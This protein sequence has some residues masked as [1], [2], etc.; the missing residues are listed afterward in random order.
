MNARSPV[1]LMS[2][3]G[4]SQWVDP[5]NK[6][7]YQMSK[8]FIVSKLISNHNKPENISCESY[9]KNVFM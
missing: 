7:S 8:G 9:T 6:D 3:A 5:E 1:S 2:C 4:D